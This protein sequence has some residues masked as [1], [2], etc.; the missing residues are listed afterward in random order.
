MLR[1]I[2]RDGMDQLAAFLNGASP[3]EGPA[4]AALALAEAR[5]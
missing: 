3:D 4:S 5:P 1:R 2:A